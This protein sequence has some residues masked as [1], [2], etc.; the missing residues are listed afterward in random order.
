MLTILSSVLCLFHPHNVLATDANMNIWHDD[1]T[2]PAAMR[3]V[4]EVMSPTPTPSGAQAAEIAKQYIGVP[5]VWGGTTPEGF[6]CSGLMQYVYK[7]LG[8]SISRTTSTQ[9]NDG[10]AVSRDE[11]KQGDLI[12][13]GH[14][15][16]HVGM[17]VGD[18]NFIE[19]PYSGAYVRIT[20]LSSRNDYNCARRI[21][22]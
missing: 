9:I 16:H 5:Y 4:E 12:L 14:P 22:E 3:S 17:Y 6:D 20:P 18:G 7:Q 10:R 11:L 15:V 2:Q 13:F 19:A 8:I 21:V 1:I